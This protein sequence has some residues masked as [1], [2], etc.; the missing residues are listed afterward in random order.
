MNAATEKA[1]RL[2][3][4][5][6]A[7]SS[8]REIQALGAVAAV[9][10]AG[11]GLAPEPTPEE[12]PSSSGALRQARWRERQKRV[13]RVTPVTPSRNTTK[14][15]EGGGSL[16]VFEE[17]EERDGDRKRHV[18]FDRNAPRDALGDGDRN[19]ERILLRTDALD[20]DLTAI[21]QLASVQDIAGAW[22]KFTGH[23]AD[24]WIHVAGRWQIWCQR[25]AK[26][27]RS[28]RDR[29]RPPEVGENEQGRRAAAAVERGEATVRKARA[30]ERSA[31]P[32]P[33]DLLSYVKGG[34]P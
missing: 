14:G 2:I 8:S 23:Y 6:G 13:G 19:A 24:K 15:G 9:A 10:L 25:E 17:L 22:L 11:E 20:E 5:A 18:T 30:Y 28:E 21:A 27:E 29:R 34:K 33:T 26:I 7:T 16:S 32:P 4:R 3:V 12:R 1:L 31:V